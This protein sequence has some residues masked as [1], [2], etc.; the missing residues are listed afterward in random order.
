M[1]SRLG[2]KSAMIRILT[3]VMGKLKSLSFRC[4]SDCRTIELGYTC[5]IPGQPCIGGCGDG[6]YINSEGCEDGNLVSN[7]GCSRYC[8][9]E[10]GWTCKHNG[11]STDTCTA[12]CGDGLKL[13]A[14]TCDDGN[15]SNLDGYYS[16]RIFL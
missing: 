15:T 14:E 10:N 5:P 2:L 7:D 13:G 12:K 16:F 1:A 3:V 4:T 11:S 9:V 6:V 8:T